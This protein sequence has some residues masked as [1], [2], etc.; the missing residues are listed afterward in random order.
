MRIKY[1][2]IKAVNSFYP[3]IKIG[4]VLEWESG[5]SC[6]IIKRMSILFSPLVGRDQI[7][8][9]IKNKYIKKYENRLSK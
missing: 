2:F 1:V 3:R 4:D 9:L 6:Y 5:E 7:K 8:E